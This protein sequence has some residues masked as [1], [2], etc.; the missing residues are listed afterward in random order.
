[1]LSCCAANLH[2]GGQEQG[3]VFAHDEV[4]AG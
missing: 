4:T 3:I 1:M 2:G